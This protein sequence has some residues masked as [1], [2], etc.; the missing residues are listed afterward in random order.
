MTATR[1]LSGGTE[2]P[3]LEEDSPR[4]DADA[5]RQR[6]LD[7]GIEILQEQ[8]AGNV[9]S[10]VKAPLVSKRAGLTP[11]AFYYH[12]PKQHLFVRELLEH[13]LHPDR[14]LPHADEYYERLRSPVTTIDELEDL[15]RHLAVRNIEMAVASSR[16]AVQMAMWT[17]QADEPQI[18]ELL[19]DLYAGRERRLHKAYTAGFRS[20]GLE[21]RPPLTIETVTTILTALFEGSA[22][23][24][25]IDPH[26]LSAEM[27]AETVIVLL[28]QLL[29]P[30]A[31]PTAED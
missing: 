22:V 15:Y 24:H 13:L 11:G 19:R 29:Q 14:K 26:A 18:S 6:L 28:R 9:M 27:Y 1:S 31:N 10:H 3:F 5:T 25:S 7:A 16:F 21:P 2:L 30:V 4:S 17:R 8:A 20:A 23:R 12:W